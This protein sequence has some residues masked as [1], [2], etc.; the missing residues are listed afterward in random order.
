MSAGSARVLAPTKIIPRRVS[1]H[2]IAIPV[3]VTVLRSGVP[4]NVPG[5]CI[6]M[7]EG[8]MLA[9]LAAEFRP[10]DSVGVEFWLPDVSAP[11][12]TKAVVRHQAELQCG[13]QF[14]GLSQDQQA[15]IRYWARRRTQPAPPIQPPVM[16]VHQTTT[17]EAVAAPTARIS[18]RVLVLS[19]LI[20]I[21]LGGVGWWRW[22]RAWNELET[23]M[24]GRKSADSELLRATVPADVMQ[25]L[26]THK[27]EPLYPEDLRRANVQGVVVLGAVIGRDGSVVKLRPISGPDALASAAIDAVKWWRFQPYLVNGRAVEVETTLAVEFRPSH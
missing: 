23:R 7:G 1:R 16:T 10:G 3:D 17:T 9:I 21:A 13:F 26:I 8:G 5:R 14:L 22:Y 4:D 11:L 24:P 15:S 2:S 6:D 12:R 19:L 27:V 20:F 25:Q 18:H